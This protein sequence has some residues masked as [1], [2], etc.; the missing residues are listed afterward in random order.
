[1]L[2]S[3][4]PEMPSPVSPVSPMY[5][6]GPPEAL[7]GL[8]LAPPMVGPPSYPYFQA[9]HDIQPDPEADAEE[10]QAKLIKQIE[11]YFRW[12]HCTHLQFQEYLLNSVLMLINDFFPFDLQ[13][14]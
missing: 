10:N 5:Y 12:L 13:Q 7:R 9:P 2:H 4:Y 3:L 1:M 6:F 8:A 14:G 11:F